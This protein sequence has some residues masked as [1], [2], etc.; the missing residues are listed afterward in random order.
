MRTWNDYKEY[1]RNT[2]SDV[3]LDLDEAEQLAQ[4]IS[5]LNLVEHERL[6]GCKTY[7]LEEAREILLREFANNDKQRKDAN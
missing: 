7:S 5:K 4:L 6:A 3:S 1:V 2:D